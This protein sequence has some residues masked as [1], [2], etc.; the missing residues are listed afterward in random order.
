MAKNKVGRKAN[1]KYAMSKYV[2]EC[3]SGGRWVYD[4][5]VQKLNAAKKIVDKSNSGRAES[6]RVYNNITG[7]V[8]YPK[9]ELSNE[10]NLQQ[11]HTGF[12]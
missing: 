5:Q 12:N 7:V 4:T 11:G 3:L 9:Q 1:Y 6:F 10:E 8:V 2:I